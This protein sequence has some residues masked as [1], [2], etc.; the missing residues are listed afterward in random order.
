M[1]KDVA[2]EEDVL[3]VQ[4][5][6]CSRIMTL[7]LTK[8][9]TPLEAAPLLEVVN[10]PG[11][12][13][14]SS[15]DSGDSADSERC[16]ASPPPTIFRNRRRKPVPGA[17]LV[18]RKRLEDQPSLGRHPRKKVRP[19]QESS[20]SDDEPPEKRQEQS[21]GGP[22]QGSGRKAQPRPKTGTSLSVQKELIQVN[23]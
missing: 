20:T 17:A 14:S 11:S 12:G 8:I 16:S 23:T 3:D 4:P 19:R 10:I 6:S 18:A 21:H 22:R 1:D 5:G 9:E 13:D 7:L 2:V 15:A